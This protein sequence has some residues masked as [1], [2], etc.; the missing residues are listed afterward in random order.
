MTRPDPFLSDIADAIGG[1]LSAPVFQTS[2][3]REAV[4][5]AC[6]S[7]LRSLH[8]WCVRDVA[9]Q[10]AASGSGPLQPA[11]YGLGTA[12]R[13][14]KDDGPLRLSLLSSIAP[15]LRYRYELDQ[16]VADLVSCELR[17]ADGVDGPFASSAGPIAALL[18]RA[19]R[20]G[21]RNEVQVAWSDMEHVYRQALDIWSE[22]VESGEVVASEVA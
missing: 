3:G 16:S 22:P 14:A 20:R 19:L 13:L 11:L 1:D 17:L 4:E 2:H 10:I 12:L 6:I 15:L 7:A 21:L 9:E 18:Q 5:Q 8:R